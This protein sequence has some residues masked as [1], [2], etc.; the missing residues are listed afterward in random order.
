[1]AD[2]P[3]SLDTLKSPSIESR[4][5]H[6]CVALTV[7]FH[8]DLNRVGDVAWLD[9]VAGG[10]AVSRNEP[11]FGR[12]ALNDRNISRR[13][14]EL[15]SSDTELT[16]SNPNGIELAVDRMPVATRTVIPAARLDSGVV[17]ELAD[18]VVLLAHRARRSDGA[19]P[20]LGM[21]GAN[22][23]IDDLRRDICRVADLP[24]PVLIRGETG[25][26]KELAARAIHE[27][28][29]R[30]AKPFVA[31]NMGAIPPSTAASELFGHAKGAFT[32]AVSPHAGYFS[33]ASSGT[34]FL[35]EIGATPAEVQP[36]LLRALESLEIQPLGSPKTRTVDARLVAATDANLEHA[37]TT[38][39]FRAALLHRLEGFQLFLPA[40]RDRRDD[41]GR[42]F[43]YFLRE[44]L[45]GTGEL[46]RL[47]PPAKGEATWLP[48]SFVADLAMLDWPGNVRQLRA[49]VR[50]LVISNRGSTRVR[51]DTALQRLVDRARGSAAET[52][53][54][55]A[56]APADITDAEIVAAMRAA[57]HS[58]NAA[59][60]ALGMSRSRLYER[61]KGIEEIRQ[62]KD[63][64]DNEIAAARAAHAGD[65]GEMARALGVSKRALANRIRELARD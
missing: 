58:A 59:A 7:A 45:E 62:A 35:D 63:L 12:E 64:D 40:L 5:D 44:E 49:V 18:R 52:A 14:F 60:T 57:D 27:A 61:I 24:V 8:P 36:M 34:L 47:Q 4:G 29:S 33:Q 23:S 9:D 22:Q 19:P 46:H 50:Q 54:Q 30:R 11:V 2:Q 39:S 1:M 25:T 38:D 56:R 20:A 53:R 16:I 26:G 55:P 6:S 21:V 17:I 10:V 43:V 37:T 42:L 32:G 31:V 65:V 13:S 3:A 15:N 48:S 51:V 41:I 28:S